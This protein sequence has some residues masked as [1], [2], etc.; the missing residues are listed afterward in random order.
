[1]ATRSDADRERTI[2]VPV[3][4]AEAAAGVR[5]LA[6]G[7]QRRANRSL[8]GDA[9]AAVELA[10]AAARVGARLVELNLRGAEDERLDRALAAA[11]R[12]TTGP[13]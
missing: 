8:M 4:I 5:D 3:E 1:V 10:A 12:T 9:E 13:R 7:L 6:A 11:G 2:D